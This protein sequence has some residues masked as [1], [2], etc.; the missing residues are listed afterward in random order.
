M[1]ALSQLLALMPLVDPAPTLAM[2]T[3]GAIPALVLVKVK[4]PSKR[5]MF[6]FGAVLLRAATPMTALALT[7]AS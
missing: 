5:A 1:M 6:V 3:R 7:S 4:L 2:L